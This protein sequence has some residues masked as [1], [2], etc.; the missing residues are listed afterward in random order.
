MRSAGCR[1]RLYI[2]TLLLNEQPHICGFYLHV[3]IV[4]SFH[5]FGNPC[6]RYVDII[7]FYYI[8]CVYMHLYRMCV[9]DTQF[10]GSFFFC[11]V[12]YADC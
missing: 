3:S 6:S 4:H 7:V 12:A 2:S 5:F 10:F 1:S 11:V 8:R 9:R